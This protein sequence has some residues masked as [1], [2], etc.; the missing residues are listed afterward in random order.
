ML[1]SN[2]NKYVQNSIQTATPAQLL[3]M[4]YDGAIKF[5]KQA[6]EAIEKKNYMEA[7]RNLIKVQDIVQEFIITLDHNAPV[8]EGLLKLYDYFMYLLVQ[9]NVKKNTKPLEELLG[10]LTDL[11]ETWVQAA[12]LASQQKAS[13]GENHG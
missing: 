7:H 5:T 4:L 8:A 9:G 13:I 2:R 6:M 12:R 3:I 10:Y 11:K 1:H